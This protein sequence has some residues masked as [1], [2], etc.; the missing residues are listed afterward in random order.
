MIPTKKKL[1][2]AIKRLMFVKSVTNVELAK[3]MEVTTTTIVNIRNGLTS[4]ETMAKAFHTLEQ[5]KRKHI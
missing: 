4:Y 1:A 2:D 3:M 5:L